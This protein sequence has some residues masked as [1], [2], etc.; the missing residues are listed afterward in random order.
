[1][2]AATLVSAWLA[3]AVQRL[4]L[5]VGGSAVAALPQPCRTAPLPPRR[6]A[7][8]RCALAED[9]G[10]MVTDADLDACMLDELCIAFVSGNLKKKSEVNAILGQRDFRPFRVRHVN[11]DLPELQGDPLSI[12][13]AKCEAAAERV[14]SAVLVEDTSLC[15]NALNG[16]P[17]PYI[18]WFFQSL[19]N[20]GLYRLLENHTDKSAYCQCVLGFSSGP[21]AEPLLFTG[22]TRGHV[23]EPR[24]DAGFG[25]DAI[26]VADA[27]EMPFGAMTMAEK[28]RISHRSRALEKFV[29]YCEVHSEQMLHEIARPRVPKAVEEEQLLPL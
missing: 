23:I 4:P 15:F 18:K 22:I 19:G 9:D 10:A 21:G 5:A 29:A 7:H 13:R 12:C 26:F 8:A 2:L 11:I 17:G 25:W 27:Y 16:M 20:E 1:M 6:S 3:V 14:G 28:N 24:G